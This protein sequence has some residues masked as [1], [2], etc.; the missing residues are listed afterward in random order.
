MVTRIL[1]EVTAGQLRAAV[2]EIEAQFPDAMFCG[3]ALG[4][5]LVTDG[6]RCYIAW[7]DLADGATVNWYP[8]DER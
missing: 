1:K 5:L 3:N 8:E 4:N 7:V 2:D 6:D